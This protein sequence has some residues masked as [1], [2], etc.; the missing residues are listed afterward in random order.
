M[1]RDL[2]L[3]AFAL[4]TWGIGEGA[5]VGFQTL[6]LQE[7]GADPLRIG[8]IIGGFGLAASLAHIPAGYLSDRLGRRPLLWVAWIIGAIAAWI[9]ATANS[10]AVF[11]AGMMLYGITAFV[12]S[13]LNS[14][15]TAA[16]GRWSVGRVLTLISATYNTGA[17]LGPLLGGM[18]GERY[19]YQK[20]FLFSACVFILSTLIILFIRPQPVDTPEPEEK[21]KNLIRNRRYLYFIFAYSLATFAM[22]LPQPLSPN[23]LQ[24]HRGLGPA[25]IGQLY[26]ISSVGIVI[27]NLLLG[28]LNARIG[29]LIGQVGVAIFALLLWRGDQF[30]IYGLAFFILGGFRLARSLAT[31]HIRSIV[32]QSNMGLAYGLAETLTAISLLFAP[33]LAG[34]LY[35]RDPT[36]IYMFSLGIIGVSVLVNSALSA[37]PRTPTKIEEGYSTIE[38]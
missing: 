26:S 5:F 30:L 2:I 35:D 27:L 15:I 34:Y 24:N 37:G 25:Q 38:T 12:I 21:G 19:G 3:M 14:Y 6:Y 17:I 31:A 20:I 22:Y 23:F 33:L 29:Y 7:L 18:I 13:P 8:T 11:V 32:S 10:L 36:Q 9:M 1:G 4:T 28:Q 16:R